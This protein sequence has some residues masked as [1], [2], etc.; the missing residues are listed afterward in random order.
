VPVSSQWMGIYH[1]YLPVNPCRLFPQEEAIL[2]F[3]I[4]LK[5]EKTRQMEL[6]PIIP[7][8]QP[9]PLCTEKG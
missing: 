5:M 7:F 3:S 9:L 1:F 6:L 4:K 2:F 8:P